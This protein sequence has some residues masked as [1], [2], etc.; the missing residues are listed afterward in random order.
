MKVN[1]Q[2]VNIDEETAA[3][4]RQCALQ[5]Y[6]AY[7]SFYGEKP[8]NG[9]ALLVVGGEIAVNGFAVVE[10]MDTQGMRTDELLYHLCAK[11]GKLSNSDALTAKKESMLRSPNL[12]RRELLTGIRDGFQTFSD[13]PLIFDEMCEA[14][15]GCR[16]C[17]SACPE[18]ALKFDRGLELDTSKCTKCGLC[19]SNCP[20]AAIQMPAFSEDA[21]AGLLDGM[22]RVPAEKKV[23]VLTSTETK[24]V[25]WVHFEKL[26]T[27]M[28]S[29]R[30]LMMALASGIDLLVIDGSVDEELLMAIRTI[31]VSTGRIELG[32]VESALKKHDIVMGSRQATGFNRF[33]SWFNYISSIRAVMK[34]G[35]NAEGLGLTDLK[36]SDTCTLCGACASNCPHFA[37]K[38][39]KGGKL[40]FNPSLCTGCGLCANVCPEGSIS[41][42]EQKTL[43]LKPATVYEDELIKCARCG[44]PI[45]TKKFYDH[46]VAQLGKEDPMLKYCNECKQRIIYERLFGR[47]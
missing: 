10:T 43:S 12:S 2:L 36:V 23:L 31:S 40:L 33:D 11:I 17:I 6:P 15:Y 3:I 29:P 32:D 8:S 39:D 25:P 28:V 22:G 21:F 18:G 42:E 1:I 34:E 35:S 13:Y 41:I 27:R 47:K 19:A 7:V 16:E 26:D 20:V 9:E 30:W 14:K 5:N 46:L 37:L 24:R 4:I 45:F 38:V 44:K